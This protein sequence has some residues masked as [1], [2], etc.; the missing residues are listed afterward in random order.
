MKNII[1]LNRYFLLMF[2]L[3]L[4][5]LNVSCEGDDL[6][7]PSLN[8][9]DDEL[10]LSV[11]SSEIELQEK[12]L[13]NEISFNWSTGTNNGTDSAISYTLSIAEASGDYSEALMQPVEAQK[14]VYSWSIDYGTLNHRLLEN[15]LSAG[16]SYNLKARVTA[17]VA[18]S[19]DTQTAETTFAVSTF[20][21]ISDKL[22][23]TGDATPNGWDI[24]N[25]VALT[26]SNSQRGV[27]YYEGPLTEG[28]FK[29]ATSR[30]NCFCQDFYTRNPN[31][32]AAIVYNEGGSGDDVQWEVTE[33]DTY[34]LRVDLLNRTISIETVADAPFSKLWIVGDAT[35]SGWNVEN[36]AEFTRSEENSFIFT[37]EGNFKPGEFKVFA[38][39]LGDFC[40]D[41]YRPFENGQEIMNGE[42]EQS[43]G[44]D[45]DNKW[46]VTE[47]TAGR[48][49]ITLNTGDNTIRFEKVKMYI[50]GDGSPSGWNI[51]SPM[52]LTYEN[53][54]FVFSGEL[55]ADNPTGEFKFSKF[56]GDWCLGE[57]INSANASQAL[58]NTDFIRTQGCDGP[59]NKWKIQDGQAGTYEIRINLDTDTMT[60]NHQ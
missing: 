53:G 46:K 50:V 32:D 43:A 37:Y 23:I 59:D 29:F 34:K 19:G 22:F 25:A 2:T 17:T 57:W 16:E 28:N 15:G 60:I 27:F 42:V 4:G 10:S 14:N 36:P 48:Y 30:D 5:I 12:F 11:S 45:P 21:P 40:G 9:V 38:G 3:M 26:P 58:S 54:D 44:C 33:A 35:E 20:K 24:E 6:E 51:Q 41:W 8:N 52:E 56:T 55:G 13:S 39:P 47:E 1:K 31:D 7:D 49:K 18:S